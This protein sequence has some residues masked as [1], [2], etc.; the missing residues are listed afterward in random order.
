MQLW[1]L[2]SKHGINSWF[3]NIQGVLGGTG[4]PLPGKEGSEKTSG[5]KKKESLNSELPLYHRPSHNK[6]TGP[7]ILSHPPLTPLP[8]TAHIFC[9]LHWVGS[10]IITT[11]HN[12]LLSVCL[13]CSCDCD[14]LRP[15]RQHPLC[16]PL[17][18]PPIEQL[19]A[20]LHP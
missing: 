11:I 10:S 12:R 16:Q 18:V 2:H 3:K 13:L 5:E 14:F 17:F 7:R 8:Y 1:I 6:P 9:S 15:V 20:E 19:S 4:A